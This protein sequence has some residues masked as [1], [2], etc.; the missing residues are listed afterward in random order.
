MALV[1][2]DTFGAYVR[3]HHPLANGARW[4]DMAPSYLERGVQPYEYPFPEPVT[5][6][7]GNLAP[8]VV[9]R[10]IPVLAVATS[11]PQ[12]CHFGLWSGWGWLH[13]QSS[14]TLYLSHAPFGLAAVWHWLAVHRLHRQ[15]TTKAQA[16]YDF[17]DSCPVQPWWGARDM[18]LFDGPLD[19]VRSIGST[20]LVDDAL[21]RQSPQRWWPD[22]ESWF[23]GTEIDYPWTYVA[24]PTEL[25]DAVLADSELEAVE[26]HSEDAW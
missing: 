7:E 17:V 3:I 24:G 2:P 22:D 21:N 11:D 12:R 9:D 20:R 6:V 15:E 4:G 19:A 8:A 13:R 14:S 1:V 25:V 10:L 26:V 18:V 16:T 5:Q 23:V